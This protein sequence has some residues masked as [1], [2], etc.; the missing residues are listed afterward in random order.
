MSQAVGP[1]HRA[2]GN[3]TSASRRDRAIGTAKVGTDRVN[4]GAARDS[5]AVAPQLRQSPPLARHRTRKNAPLGALL[6]P[7]VSVTLTHRW[8]LLPLRLRRIERVALQV[9]LTALA[10]LACALTDARAVPL[11]A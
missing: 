8:A 9:E 5:A 10:R 3:D 2:V 11:A 6:Q 1:S 7:P 4:H